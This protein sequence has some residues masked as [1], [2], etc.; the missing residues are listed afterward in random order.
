MATLPLG[1]TIAVS[2][3]RRLTLA[4]VLI[5]EKA[6]RVLA[7]YGARNGCILYRLS[8]SPR[9]V[10]V[11][12]SVREPGQDELLYHVAD[13]TLAGADHEILKERPGATIRRWIVG[14]RERGRG[15]IATHAGVVRLQPPVVSL[16]D[17]WA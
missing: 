4:F 13:H 11:F 1:T 8:C 6:D 15:Q 3:S 9:L 12:S 5:I 17:K 2:R 16:A 7:V 10:F 14:V